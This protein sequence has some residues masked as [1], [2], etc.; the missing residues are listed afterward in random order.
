M[1]RGVK[2]KSTARSLHDSIS[3]SSSDD[4]S[5]Q[6]SIPHSLNIRPNA[7]SSSSS[8]IIP[9]ILKRPKLQLQHHLQCS[10]P[11]NQVSNFER[12]LVAENQLPP[13]TLSPPF[14]RLR[15]H[16]KPS[17]HV[18]DHVSNPKML[19]PITS[20]TVPNHTLSLSAQDFRPYCRL[21]SRI[22]SLWEKI[23]MVFQKRR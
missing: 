11:K 10:P 3:Q 8:Q 5:I 9:G 22:K 23:Y 20:N 6:E 19:R 17:T 4:T 16:V 1:L 12:N 21:P 2:L 18:P 15:S 7:V 13:T 14:F